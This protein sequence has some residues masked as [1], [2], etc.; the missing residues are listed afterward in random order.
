MPDPADVTL[1]VPPVLGALGDLHG[2]FGRLWRIAPE[3][4]PEDR[5]AFTLAVCEIVSNVM[6]HAAVP[7][8]DTV[9]IEL[10]ADQVG[11]HAVVTDRGRPYCPPDVVAAEG[12]DLDAIGIGPDAEHG[13]GLWMANAMATVTYQRDEGRNRWTIDRP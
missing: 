1:R 7:A 9:Q 8:D 2:A 12:E 5:T 10:R 6:L 13:R 3:V 4:P 11:V